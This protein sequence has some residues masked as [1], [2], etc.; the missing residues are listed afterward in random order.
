MRAFLLSC[1]VVTTLALSACGT[2]TREAGIRDIQEGEAC[3]RRAVLAMDDGDVSQAESH[4]RQAIAA[5][6][7]HGPAHNNLGVILLERGQLYEAAEE[8]EWARRLLPGHPE[9]RVNLAI[10]LERGGRGADAFAAATTAIEVRPGHLGA[11]RVRAWVAAADGISYDEQMSDLTA[12]ASRDSQAIW[13]DWALMRRLQ[14]LDPVS[15]SAP[16]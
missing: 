1:C 10:A 12:I 3:Y 15:A 16:E 9:P 6:L 14:L 7:Y 4:L 13:R 5:D 8:F 11:M 2:S